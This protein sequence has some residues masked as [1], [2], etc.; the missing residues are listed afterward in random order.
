MDADDEISSII[1]LGVEGKNVELF[2]D[3]LD[4]GDGAFTVTIGDDKYAA[5]EYLDGQTPQVKPAT[6]I[7]HV[8]VT[9]SGGIGEPDKFN[10]EVSSIR[11]L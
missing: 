1:F 6:S 11:F 2:N 3:N 7:L 9:P 10:D 4:D 5:V 8:D